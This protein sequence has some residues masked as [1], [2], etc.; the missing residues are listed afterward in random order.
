LLDID[1]CGPSIPK[2]TGVENEAVTVHP[3]LTGWEPAFVTENL[4]VMSVGFML[5]N[6]N[7][8]VIWKGPKKNGT[9]SDSIFPTLYS[10]RHQNPGMIKQFLRDVLWDELDY[11]IIDTP[12]GTSDEHLS[13]AQYLKGGQLDGAILITTP[14][15]VSLQDVRKEINFCQKVK[16]PVLGVVENMSGFVCVKCQVRK[17]YC[18]VA[19]HHLTLCL[20]F[21]DGN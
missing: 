10:H 16:I 1:I 9:P 19:H 12:P 4:S 5:K 6:E 14:Q 18:L 17:T 13:I 20:L 7:D 15:E 21:S 3:T 11:L 2:I 8:A